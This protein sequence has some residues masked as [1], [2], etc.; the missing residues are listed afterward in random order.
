[1]IPRAYYPGWVNFVRHASIKIGYEPLD[2]ADK[3][4]Q[5]PQWPSAKFYLAPLN[6]DMERDPTSRIKVWSVRR[7]DRV[8]HE[9]WSSGV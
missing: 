7:S 6:H 9:T 2:T 8:L 4:T 3:S 1:M 5:P